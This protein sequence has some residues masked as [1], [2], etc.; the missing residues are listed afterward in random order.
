MPDPARADLVVIAHPRD[1]LTLSAEAAEA[2]A[3]GRPLA[4][5]SE[6]PFWDSLFSPDPAARS[7]ILPTAHLGE[8]RARQVTHHRGAA[9]DFDRIPY[10]LLTAAGFWLSYSAR[11]ARNAR[12]TAADWR[13]HFAAV[14]ART[15]FMAERRPER[16]HDMVW[17]QAGI[18]G[19]CAWRTRLALACPGAERIGASWGTAPSRFALRDWHFDKLARLDAAVGTL[20]ALENTHQPA[21]LSEKLFDAFACG[22]RPLYM[23]APGHRVHDLGLPPGAWLNL[24]G[25]DLAESARAAVT[26]PEGRFFEDYAAA[27]GRLA[28]LF[29]SLEVLRAER[30]RLGRAIRADLAAAAG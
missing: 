28:A 10:Y 9:F 16:F 24:W 23:A 30:R 14:G 18:V 26:P 19:L 29:A 8:A 5:Y 7:V 11:F 27:Q 13:A 4:L 25:R 1:A 3:R 22:A 15:V 20:S 2:L 6:E 21:Y 17:P 12:R